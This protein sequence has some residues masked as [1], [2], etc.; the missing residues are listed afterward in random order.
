MNQE[1]KDR[2]DAERVALEQELLAKQQQLTKLTSRRMSLGEGSGYKSPSGNESQGLSESDIEVTK[3]KKKRMRN[4]PGKQGAKKSRNEDI[5]SDA[6]TSCEEMEDPL[7][8]MEALVKKLQCWVVAPALVTK[9][10]K[11]Q[12]A[13]FNKYIGMLREEIACAREER[14]RMETREK[15]RR[16]VGDIV[17]SIVKEEVG[18]LKTS[19]EEPPRT[20]YALAARRPLLGVPPISGSTKPVIDPP[21]QVMIRHASKESEEVIGLLKQLVKPSEIGLKV[22]RLVR[23]KNGVIVE[24]E[25]DEG[26]ER[27]RGQDALREAGLKAERPEKKRPVIKIFDVSADLTEDEIRNEIF[28]RN[29]RGSE[30]E[31]DDFLSEFKIRHRYKD[32]NTGGSKVHLVVECS[33][34]IRNWLRARERVY[35]EWQGCRV[36]DYVD[37]ARCYKCQRFGHIAKFC[38]S[39]KPS[40]SYCAGEH[41]FKDCNDKK[42]KEKECCANCKRERRDN[43]NHHVGWK[44]CPAYEKAMRMKNQKTDYGV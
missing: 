24:A 28:L 26:A 23:V 15:E 2:L 43:S 37:V 40:C 14:A 25:T 35:I 4:S 21:K 22:R 42:N 16:D 41:E 8:N 9:V 17:R 3:Q 6:E 34:R 36:K 31:R 10:S 20:T 19:E 44:K 1:E 18:K 13:K 7:A 33:G 38:Q 12:A 27:L 32:T 30:I 29:M 5:D 39:E 11:P